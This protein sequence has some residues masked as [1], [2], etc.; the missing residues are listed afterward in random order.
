MLYIPTNVRIDLEWSVK[1]GAGNEAEDFSRSIASLFLFSDA[2]R[3]PVPCEAD[4][5]GVV[6]AQLPE[7]LPEGVYSL[8]LLWIKNDKSINET[9]CV[10]RTRKTCVFVIDASVRATGST[11]A[12]SPLPDI[13]PISNPSFGQPVTLKI[14]TVAAPYGYD[15]LS[16]Y[17]SA[18]LRGTTTLDEYEWSKGLFNDI[19]ARELDRKLEATYVSDIAEIGSGEDEPSAGGPYIAGQGISISEENIISVNQQELDQM[20]GKLKGYKEE[21]NDKGKVTKVLFSATGPNGDSEAS[22]TH[23][24]AVLQHKHWD[25]TGAK[26]T[27]DT[28]ITME[29]D[30]LDLSKCHRIVGLKLGKGLTLDE[31]GRICVDLRSLMDYTNYN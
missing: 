17:E 11:R 5:Q 13:A 18:V 22:C 29:G 7:T 9:R 30:T 23:E 2:N 31:D 26:V 20:Q 4:Y 28:K 24:A 1:K 16:A 8:E 15:G 3:W 14:S 6:S 10:Q 19:L 12:V 27:V 25:G 21:T